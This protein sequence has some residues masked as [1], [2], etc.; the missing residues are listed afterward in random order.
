M[1]NTITRPKVTIA[2]VM[3]FDE[4]RRIEVVNG[5]IKDN[6]VIDGLSHA[7]VIV[8]LY[9]ILKSFV[10]QQNIA[11]VYGYGLTYILHEDKTE[12]IRDT[13][14][15][16]F[17]FVRPGLIPKD[18]DRS[19]PFPGCPALAVEIVSPTEKTAEL[20]EK[21]AS[22]LRYDTEQVWVIYPQ[23]QELHQYLKDNLPPRVYT[24][25][26]TLTAESL[27]PGLVINIADLFVDEYE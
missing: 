6:T 8:N 9:E 3:H 17:S 25:E 10:R 22:F 21:I 20:M 1:E 24:T 18:W 13:R 11:Y 16:D 15:P 7:A 2:D 27:F 12:G 23:S 26:D 5:Q 4:D 19:R 14:I